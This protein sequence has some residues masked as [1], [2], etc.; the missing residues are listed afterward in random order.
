MISNSTP[1]PPS[2]RQ[3]FEGLQG[4]VARLAQALRTKDQIIELQNQKI[5]L[6]NFK[7]WGPK[8]DTISPAQ[9]A[10]LFE[11]ASV[12]AAEIQTEAEQ[13]P[14]QKE[15]PL[16]KAKQ[17]RPNHPGREKLP[18]HLER[19]EVIIPCHPKDCRCDQCGA[20]RP[21]IGYER[22]EELVCD[23]ATFHVRVTLREKRGSHCQEE[24]GVATAPAPAKIVPKSKLSNEFIIE[25]L[26]RKYQQHT[27]IYRQCAVLADNHGIDLS[28]ATLTSAIL[29]AGELLSAVVRAQADELREGSYL[30]A[31]ET[32]VPVQ[33]G[34]KSGRNH[35]AY[36]WEY[37]QPGGPV[38]FDFQMGRGREGPEKFLRGFRGT[39]QCDGYAAYD[40]LGE[41]IVYAGCLA[42]A[43]RGFVEA[44]KLAPQNPLP[45]EIVERIGAALRGG[46][47]SPASRPGTG[48]TT[49]PAPKPKRAGHGGV[50]TA[51]GGNP[52]A[53]PARRQTGPS[54][55][56]HPGPVEPAGGLLDKRP[57]GNRQQLVRRGD[58]PAG[59]GPQKLAA[60]WQP[61]SRPQS[62]GHR[63]H[64]RNLPALGH[65]SA[66]L[67]QRHPAQ[68]GR[69]AGQP[70]CRAD[71]DRLESGAIQKILTS[72]QAT[73]QSGLRLDGVSYTDTI[74]QHVPMPLN[75]QLIACN[76]CPPGAGWS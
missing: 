18:E 23:P 26:A 67:S 55:R 19:R 24:Q 10:L 11:E 43:R 66:R 40:K 44:A 36:P 2:V 49:S 7:L 50:E 27:P 47:K 16:P 3:A 29:A 46:R 48:G 69:L 76:E 59:A 20:E 31:D 33:T 22:S 56:L 32:T 58:A 68:T 39:L 37:S 14:A 38:V 61:G 12:T 1:C 4:E 75:A 34:E 45:V 15:N 65:Q 41:G 70:R 53:N 35:Q 57:G 62:G 71:P 9:T 54:L 13:P 60:P 8:G 64:R 74:L 28:R 42:H 17:P 51:A 52:P 63:L 72:P 30:Q 21:V 25:A 5:R 73:A 6:L